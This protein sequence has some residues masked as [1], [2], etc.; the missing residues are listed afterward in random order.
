MSSRFASPGAQRLRTGPHGGDTLP[1]HSI[2]F[3]S[4][5]TLECSEIS[6]APLDEAELSA[7]RFLLLVA[8]V[9]ALFVF[10]VVVGYATFVA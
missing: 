3:P 9:P 1:Q 4:G 6:Q 8:F 10:L 2:L 5:S 7:C